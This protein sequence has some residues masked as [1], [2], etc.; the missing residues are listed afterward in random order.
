ME[1]K[2]GAY[3]C[4]GDRGGD[5]S[6]IKGGKVVGGGMGGG[7]VGLYIGEWDRDVRKVMRVCSATVWWLDMGCRE[8]DWKWANTVGSRRGVEGQ[9]G[10]WFQTIEWRIRRRLDHGVGWNSER[11]RVRKGALCG[12]LAAWRQNAERH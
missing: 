2:G 12:R 3:G 5:G 1:G 8:R 11:N 9:R 6:R 4:W 10:G 7:R